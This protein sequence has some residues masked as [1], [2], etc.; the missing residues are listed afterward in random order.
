[1]LYFLLVDC[2]L[3]LIPKSLKNSSPVIQGIK[4]YG[5]IGKI[6]DVSLH[7]SCMTGLINKNARG[8]PDILHHIMIDAL[9]SPLNK[10]NLLR[11]Y[12]HT[13]DKNLV[14]EINPMM[15]P[16]KDF[17]RFKG[18]IFHLLDENKL[19]IPKEILRTR[20]GQLEKKK[21]YRSKV[22]EAFPEP[23][24]NGPPSEF[25]ES[26]HFIEGNNIILAR[27]MKKSIE[28]LI[29]FINPDRVMKFMKNGLFKT[30]NKLFHHVSSMEHVIVIVGGF[31]SGAYSNQITSIKGEN[32][33][34]FPE[35]LESWTVAQRILVNYEN[36]ILINAQKGKK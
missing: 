12:F 13:R 35:N 34:I 9:S 22:V 8:R 24:K 25:L 16:P 28:M 36:M 10:L 6:L 27:K 15:K 17:N 23:L 1:M 26:E 3:E 11:I 5:D 20:R 32:I 7:H 14:F 4:K 33:S 31:Q 30:P 2:A 18:V 19:T 21:N 29:N